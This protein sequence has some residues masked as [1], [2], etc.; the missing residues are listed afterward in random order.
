M[1]LR[2]LISVLACTFTVQVVTVQAIAQNNALSKYLYA[3]DWTPIPQHDTSWVAG[4]ILTID[5]N[6]G[7]IG[8]IDSTSAQQALNLE[9]GQG[10]F[11][12]DKQA[13]FTDV[14]AGLSGL[15]Q[16]FS[17]LGLSGAVKTDG[18]L[19]FSGMQYTSDV[20]ADGQMKALFAKD[21]DTYNNIV[22]T[23]SRAR[24][25]VLGLFGSG[26]LYAIFIVREVA[27]A[28]S[29]HVTSTTAVS[30]DAQAGAATD[31]GSCSAPQL[32]A[33]L[34]QAKQ[35][36][37]NAASP[38]TP[39]AAESAP[40]G[41]AADQNA[42]TL[43]QA[44]QVKAKT[45]APSTTGTAGAKQSDAAGTKLSARVYICRATDRE[46]TFASSKPLPVAMKLQFIG[47]YTDGTVGPITTEDN[48]PVGVSNSE[49]KSKALDVI[50]RAYNTPGPKLTRIF[51]K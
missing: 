38:A 11:D 31:V 25:P 15:D 12:V 49:V 27:L 35:E 34:A 51:Q 1:S 17:G 39:P 20:V 13:T 2:K 18:S 5:L 3:N 7:H 29:A 48:L 6:S 10:I 9:H 8:H 28:T 33:D 22:S 40:A 47:S 23:Y 19:S 36:H 16:F 44:A 30:V 45:D 43:A 4:R 14:N 32:P 21:S 46:V 26:P 42:D 37:G 24:H 50:H 41:T